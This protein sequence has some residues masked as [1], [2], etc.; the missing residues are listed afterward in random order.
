MIGSY[1]IHQGQLKSAAQAFISLDDI[2][3]TYGYGVY[4][5][6][7]VRNGVIYFSHEHVKR[8]LHSSEIIGIQKSFHEA[9]IAEWIKTLVFKNEITETNIKMLCIGG[10]GNNL[11]DIYIFCMNP[12]YPDKSLYENGASVVLFEG[13]RHYPQA[14][15]LS[16]LISTMAYRFAADQGCYD[17]LLV[18]SEG[19][20]T[21]GTRTNVFFLKDNV[22]SAP[23]SLNALEGVTKH[24]LIECLGKKGITVSEKKLA[25]DELT[26]LDGLFLT[27][28]SSKVMPVSA[29]NKIRIS[30]PQITRE[31]MDMYALFL[32]E[33]SEEIKKRS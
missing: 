11:P 22:L 7:K 3:F 1:F 4:E 18:N 17:A 9:E 30:I 19:Y 16:M 26:S 25:R 6:L 13:E 23:P 27:S 21:E 12:V 24:T 14:K 33:Y 10:K 32:K 31:I 29:V 5:T 15:S 2:N 28:T 8:L 20:I